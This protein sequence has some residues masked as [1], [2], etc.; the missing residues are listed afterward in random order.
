[1]KHVF[2]KKIILSILL[3][4]VITILSIIGTGYLLFDSRSPLSYRIYSGLD[5]DT[6]LKLEHDFTNLYHSININ[7]RYVDDYDAFYRSTTPFLNKHIKRLQVVNNS[8]IIIFDSMDRESSLQKKSLD[9]STIQDEDHYF[10][11]FTGDKYTFSIPIQVDAERVAT[12]IITTTGSVK[13]SFEQF[14]I[15]L[16]GLFIFGLIVFILLILFFSWWV[17]RDMIEP[18]KR[19]NVSAANISQG[20]LDFEVNYKKDNELGHFCRIFDTMRI[21]LKSLLERQ[22]AYERSRKELIA[23]MSHDLRTPLTSIKGYVEGLEDGKGKNEERFKRYLN[24]IRNNVNRLDTLIEDLFQFSQLELG[25]LPMDFKTQNCSVM[26]ESIFRN[27][28]A[29]FKDTD[30][31]FTVQ[32]PLPSAIIHADEKRITQVLENLISNAKRYIPSSG[33]ITVGAMLKDQFIKI[34]VEDNGVGISSDALPYI[35]DLCYREEESRS[36]DYG[37]V[38]LGL[39]ICK[40]IIEMHDGEIYAESVQNAGTTFYFTIPLNVL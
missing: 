3:T 28:E 4:T 20:N 13:T 18:L 32:R 11:G 39:T 29:E 26:L 15:A 23:S 17:S 10:M 12:G 36:T 14:R 31:T 35:F 34:Y 7:Y 22:S 9:T 2:R 33:H 27:F 30:I 37:G 38:G 8:D 21:E 24:V 19:L 16:L 1:M 5:E 25:D 40:K 6:L